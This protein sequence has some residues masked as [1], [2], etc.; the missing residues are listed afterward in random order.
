MT[1]G[2][3]DRRAG[4]ERG[5]ADMGGLLDEAVALI[6]LW[7]TINRAIRKPPPRITPGFL[8]CLLWVYPVKLGR[9]RV[10]AAGRDGVVSPSGGGISAP[11]HPTP[12]PSASSPYTSVPMTCVSPVNEGPSPPPPKQSTSTGSLGTQPE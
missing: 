12:S 6:G 8:L 7:L 3:R 11:S 5:S 1:F 9:L 4:V 10:G 2:A